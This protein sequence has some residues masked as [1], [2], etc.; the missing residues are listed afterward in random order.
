MKE[1]G[2]GA[3]RER[4]NFL[5]PT[6]AFLLGCAMAAGAMAQ[7]YP[8]KPVRIVVPFAPGGGTDVIARFLATGLSESVKRQFIVENRAGA[9]AIVGTEFVAR[10][11]ADGYTL[12]F[13]SSP[14]SVNPS[15]YPKLPYDTLRDFA[16]VSMV[17]SSPYFLVVH[18][19]LPARRVP[20]RW[21]RN[22]RTRFSIP[23]GAAAA[24]RTS[25]P[26]CSTR[27]RA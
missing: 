4:V 13:V 11:P 7:Q 1:K 20:S 16:P 26:S 17:A 22:G 23:P 6:F 18:P 27:W 9:N 8:A 25:P 3:E 19:S 24:P 21:Q 15:V 5:L 14:H 12:L 10:A 2:Q